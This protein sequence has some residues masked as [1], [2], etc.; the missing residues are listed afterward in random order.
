MH[1]IVSCPLYGM[2]NTSGEFSALTNHLL[3]MLKQPRLGERCEVIDPSTSIVDAVHNII[4][5]PTQQKICV[6]IFYDDI[7]PNVTITEPSD[8]RVFRAG[9]IKLW[10]HKP[11]FDAIQPGEAPNNSFL[12]KRY[13]QCVFF[14]D[15]I[16]LSRSDVTIA[17]FEILWDVSAIVTHRESRRIDLRFHTL[18]PLVKVVKSLLVAKH[19]ANGFLVDLSHAILVHRLV[20]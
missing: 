8:I 14:N 7:W 16:C 6:Q 17:E 15:C 13:I 1:R 11:L 19:R 4:C 9:Q 5:F 2:G 18:R 3:F 10:S 20:D 12:D